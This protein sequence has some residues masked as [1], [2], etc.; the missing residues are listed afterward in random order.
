MAP[1]PGGEALIDG[2]ATEAIGSQEYG[3]PASGPA[4]GRG[5]A[6]YLRSPLGGARIV[7]LGDGALLVGERLSRIAPRGLCIL[8]I[9]IACGRQRIAER[10]E[11]A[12][13]RAHD[14]GDRIGADIAGAAVADAIVDEKTGADVRALALHIVAEA[15]QGA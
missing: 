5:G 10:V 6:L 14:V 4:E 13:A 1:Q 8:G 9:G 7:G 12:V 15:Q 11:D 3:V 2:A